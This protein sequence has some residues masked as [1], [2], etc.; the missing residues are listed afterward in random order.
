VTSEPEPGPGSPGIGGE[1]PRPEG[2]RRLAR[3]PGERYLHRAGEVAPGPPDLGRAAGAGLGSGVAL[4]VAAGLLAGL[5]DLTAGL[6]V[7]G[8]IGGWLVGRAVAAGA[9]HE[10]LFEPLARPGSP[11]G[12]RSLAAALAAAA[13]VLALGVDW[14][15]AL[16][17]LPEARTGVLDRLGSLPLVEWLTPQAGQLGPSFL[18]AALASAALAWRAAR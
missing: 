1:T 4:G 15:V 11:A 16:A 17:A 6:I 8:A 7:V 2:R 13:W 10:P 12:I 5:V 9:W 14:F 18:L 3:P